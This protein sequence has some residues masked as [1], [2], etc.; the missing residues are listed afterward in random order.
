MCER[1]ITEFQAAPQSIGTKPEMKSRQKRRPE[2]ATAASS[3]SGGDGGSDAE[4][5]FGLL[6]GRDGGRAGPSSPT[7]EKEISSDE[8]DEGSVPAEEEP[9]DEE[10]GDSAASDEGD[11]DPGGGV[12]ST[13]IRTREDIKKGVFPC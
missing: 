6:T 3:S 7:G 8:E 4:T 11:E 13:E 1:V 2:E 5:N 10:D 12:G 9:G